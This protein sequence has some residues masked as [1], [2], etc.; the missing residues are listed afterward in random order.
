MPETLPS[1]V[2]REIKDFPVETTTGPKI[3]QTNSW[4]KRRHELRMLPDNGQVDIQ[5]ELA[6]RERGRRFVANLTAEERKII[7]KQVAER[8]IAAER[9][10]NQIERLRKRAEQAEARAR[11]AENVVAVHE[12]ERQAHLE[13]M[14]DDIALEAKNATEPTQ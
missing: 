7:K 8:A 2:I 1:Q 4:T 12:A 3:K 10:Q 9:K 6:R 5:G 11:R 14:E 13:A